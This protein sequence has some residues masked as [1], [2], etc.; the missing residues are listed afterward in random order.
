MNLSGSKE[1][2]RDVIQVGAPSEGLE[3][4]TSLAHPVLHGCTPLLSLCAACRDHRGGTIH[5]YSSQQV[6][7]PFHALAFAL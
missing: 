6:A 3:S 2:S 7:W 1:K 5:V 4:R